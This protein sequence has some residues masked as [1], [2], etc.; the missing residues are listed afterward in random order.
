MEIRPLIT[1]VRTSGWFGG[2][3][4]FEYQGDTFF[5]LPDNHQTLVDYDVVMLAGLEKEPAEVF[6]PVKLDRDERTFTFKGAIQS[7]QL[8]QWITDL[9]ESTKSDTF[10]KGKV[11]GDVTDWPI[12]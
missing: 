6:P 1:E 12:K 5:A 9:E 11:L 7:H 10:E 4:A 3:L 2:S 8:S